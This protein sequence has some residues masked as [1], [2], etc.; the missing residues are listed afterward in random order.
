M[1]CLSIAAPISRITYHRWWSYGVIHRNTPTTY[2]NNS[3]I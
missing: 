3:S 2:L 1:S